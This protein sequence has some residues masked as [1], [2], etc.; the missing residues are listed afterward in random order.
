[1][2]PLSIARQLP[3]DL[4]I[5][6]LM[7]V[8]WKDWP[9]ESPIST[10]YVFDMTNLRC[11]VTVDRFAGERLPVAEPEAGPPRPPR[12]KLGSLPASALSRG[13]SGRTSPR[14]SGAVPSAL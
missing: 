14:F 2:K 3:G 12:P 10:V 8:I 6:G 13:T 5:H 7:T 4:I 1:M 11:G 9:L